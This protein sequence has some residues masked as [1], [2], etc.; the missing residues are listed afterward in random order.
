[1][2]HTIIREY[3]DTEVFKTHIA[4]HMQAFA[5][6]NANLVTTASANGATGSDISPAM[7]TY[8]SRHLLENARTNLIFEQFADEHDIPAGNGRVL[9]LRR[10]ETLPPVTQPLTEGVTP[11]S[12]HIKMAQITCTMDQFGYWIEITDLVDLTAADPIL[13]SAVEELAAQAGESRDRYVRN[14]MVLTTN[15][16]Y[17][18][19]GADQTVVTSKSGIDST[20]LPTLADIRRQVTKMKN[21][22]IKPMEDG[23]YVCACHPSFIADLR[24]ATDFKD[25]QQY[26]ESG[27]KRM[28]EGEIGIIEKV[29]FVESVNALVE[30]NTISDTDYAVFH[31][32]FIGRKSYGVTKV[33]GRGIETVIK[34]FGSGDDPL[35]QRMTA[36]WKT[37]LGAKVTNDLGIIDY[38]SGSLEYNDTPAN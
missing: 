11:S 36:G 3:E 29:R 6:N 25:W 12:G 19:K 9:N 30:K 8:Y 23:Y 7:R 15:K 2:R 20:C 21:N 4:L 10:F 18:R 35:N 32:L 38:M 27:V 31:S 28:Y 14:K 16:S 24:S 22:K 33:G 13:E 5:N 1:M 34:P 37:F 26:S 17:A